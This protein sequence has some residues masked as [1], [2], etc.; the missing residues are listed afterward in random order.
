[1]IDDYDAKK[2]RCPMLGH[3]L[4]FSYCREPS[5]ETPC[6]KI[7]DCWWE[8]FDITDFIRSHYPPETIAGIL[9]PKRPKVASLF[10]IIQ[11][12]QKNEPS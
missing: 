3:E 6:S 11:K 2:R 12:V 8:R 9:E 1:M 10:E 4:T 7:F 5:R